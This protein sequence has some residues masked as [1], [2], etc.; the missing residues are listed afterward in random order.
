M[1]RKVEQCMWTDF[2]GF[3]FDNLQVRESHSLVDAFK[4]KLV[5]AFIK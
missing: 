1:L 5:L 3:F 4:L 2:A